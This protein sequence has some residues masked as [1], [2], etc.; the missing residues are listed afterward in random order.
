MRFLPKLLA[1]A[2]FLP[3]IA[4]AQPAPQSEPALR[5]GGVVGHSLVLTGRE[6]AALPHQ[7]VK[8]ADEKGTPV[9]YEGV[10]VFEVLRRAE[11]PLGK[12][13]HGKSMTLYVMVIASDGYRAVFALPELYP[14]FSD[15]SVLIADR[16]DGKNLPLAEGPFRIVVPGEKRHGRWV[17]NVTALKIEQP[18]D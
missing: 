7:A 4:F 15:R 18:T 2:L 16:R 9:T 12:D 13:L 14:A 3:A 8:V 17:R 10:P 6:V 5:I 11:I 1:L